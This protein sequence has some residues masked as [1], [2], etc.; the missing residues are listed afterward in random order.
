MTIVPNL[1]VAG[2]LTILVSLAVL[3]F[4]AAFVQRKNGGLVLIL[5][6]IIMLPLA[7][8]RRGGLPGCTNAW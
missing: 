2:V 5:P 1:L 4:A 8:C 7:A 3:V 6:S